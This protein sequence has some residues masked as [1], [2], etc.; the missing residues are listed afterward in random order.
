MNHMS[1]KS[2]VCLTSLCGKSQFARFQL[3]FI[4]VQL[5]PGLKHTFGAKGGGEATL[6]GPG[7]TNRWHL[8]GRLHLLQ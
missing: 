5:A 3:G 2:L 1:N 8:G 6:L 7:L 4:T